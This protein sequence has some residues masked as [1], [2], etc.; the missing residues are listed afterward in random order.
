MGY[1]K[2]WMIDNGAFFIKTED[3]PK[4]SVCVDPGSKVCIRYSTWASLA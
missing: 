2:S 4:W 1:T 3:I